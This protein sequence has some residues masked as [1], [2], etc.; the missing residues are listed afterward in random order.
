[1]KTRRAMVF[2][3]AASASSLL[4]AGLLEGCDGKHAAPADT[5]RRFVVCDPLL[6]AP[7][8]CYR[9][10][11]GWDAMGWIAWNAAAR[12]NQYVS[13]VVLFNAAQ[14]KIVQ[15]TSPISEEQQLLDTAGAEWRDANLMAQTIAA[16]IN[17]GIVVPGLENFVAKGGRFSDDVPAKRRAEIEKV[18]S[19][20]R[21]PGL[22][23]KVFK[24]ECFFDCVYG[25][26]PCDAKYEFVALYYVSHP[27]PKLPAIGWSIDYDTRLVVAPRGKLAE[28]ASEGGKMIAG[29]FVNQTWKA[30]QE[31][32]MLAIATGKM[33]GANEGYELM[34]QSQAETQRTMDEIRRKRSEQIREVKTVDNPFSPGEKFERPAFFDHSW[35]NSSQD[36]LLLSDKHLEPNTIRGLIEMGDWRPV[37]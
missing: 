9:L 26:V 12:K 28:A 22:T 2:A 15:E 6:R 5:A 3:I 23:H 21:A 4:C 36:A 24:V 25:G 13:S 20:M 14:H 30:A 1:M 7:A 19:M 32:M 31:R 10:E 35:M 17:P 34:K 29:A 18:A 33:I 27:M 37:D 16:R 8:A 11:P